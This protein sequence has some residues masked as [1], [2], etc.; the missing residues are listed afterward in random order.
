[1]DRRRAGLASWAALAAAACVVGGTAACQK[2]KDYPFYDDVQDPDDLGA[3]DPGRDDTGGKDTGRDP[4][5]GDALEAGDGAEDAAPD[6]PPA[7]D[8]ALRIAFPADGAILTGTLDVQVEVTSPA[9]A[10]WDLSIGFVNAAVSPVTR[11]GAGPATLA[12]PVDTT[13]LVDGAWTLRA[14]VKD[15]K[16]QE[17]AD[18][19][20]IT[21]DNTPPEVSVQVLVEGDGG[22]V[23]GR[24]ELVLRAKDLQTGIASARLSVD[25]AKEKEWSSGLDDVS[26]LLDAKDW[27]VGAHA[28]T[29]EAT[30]RAGHSGR[31]DRVVRVV[32]PPTI[33]GF[34]ERANQWTD[35]LTGGA[36][37]RLGPESSAPWGAVLA[38]TGNVYLLEKISPAL[39]FHPIHADI[40][41]TGFQVADLDQDGMDDAVGWCAKEKSFLVLLQRQEGERPVFQEIQVPGPKEVDKPLDVRDFAL[42]DVSQDGFPDI[43]A[44][45]AEPQRPVALYR[46]SPI[47][48]SAAFRDP[49]RFAGGFDPNLV[50]VGDLADNG[51]NAITIATSAV[52]TLTVFPVTE[53]GIVLQGEN[54]FIGDLDERGNPL[55]VDFSDLLPVMHP[56]NP[57]PKA[58]HRLFL[59]CRE[60]G[61]TL[62]NL[63]SFAAV[64][65]DQ[66]FTLQRMSDEGTA[67]GPARIA[68]G[69][70]DGNGTADAVV[71]DVNSRILQAWRFTSMGVDGDAYSPGLPDSLSVGR[72][73]D[74]TLADLEGDGPKEALLI[75]PDHL[76]AASWGRQEVPRAI[77]GGALCAWMDQ[78]GASPIAGSLPAAQAT[79]YRP[80]QTVVGRF[81]HSEEE[82]APRGLDL[83]TF[84]VT[85]GGIEVPVKPFSHDPAWGVPRIPD[86]DAGNAANPLKGVVGA[87]AGDMTPDRPEGH[88]LDDVLVVND[89]CD[90]SKATSTLGAVYHQVDLTA[91]GQ[92]ETRVVA[93]TQ[94]C[95]PALATAGQFDTG[96][97]IASPEG[98]IAV[99]TDATPPTVAVFSRIQSPS[100]AAGSTITLTK[101]KVPLRKLVAASMRRSLAEATSGGPFETDLVTLNAGTQDFTVF[102]ALGNLAL[103]AEGAS[104][105]FSVG[106]PPVDMAVGYLDVPVD[107]SATPDQAA[108]HLPDVVVLSTQ[109]LHVSFSL[110]NVDEVAADSKTLEFLPPW[111]VEYPKLAT[112]T[113]TLHRVALSDVNGDGYLDILVLDRNRGELA[114]YLNL[115]DRTFSLVGRY[116]V[117]N[118]PADLLPGDL[119]GDGRIDMTTVNL[120]GHTFTFVRTFPAGTAP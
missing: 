37:I 56:A 117:G 80:N 12:V 81:F 76:V 28:I 47:A 2:D 11:S 51:R 78:E 93:N 96:R 85:I 75:Y 36:G 15:A 99:Y 6:A 4:V 23:T 5:E 46:S 119:D 39:A 8:L 114:V 83:E 44:V 103:S 49:E 3:T 34:P 58:S 52:P 1:M 45:V 7:G 108:G 55:P 91:E 22:A 16:G 94:L 112:W 109:G 67:L 61:V 30:D 115:S 32:P 24:I 62:P 73:V 43:V 68:G 25:G 86:Q 113:P 54:N 71:L 9:G 90:P 41:C 89:R 110:D 120:N 66:S 106:R 35:P 29:L 40:A 111:Y 70:L 63:R 77:D 21:I 95:Q 87:F 26:F 100:Q 107:G 105:N 20:R 65:A 69:D 64:P 10:T 53:D 92:P 60:A 118:D 98:E 14:T 88:P 104:K 42:G 84:S 50:A 18:E 79:C 74:V 31:D 102:I 19:A 72:A 48:G 97:G 82:T 101:S 116:P 38:S 59:S 17:A 33:A 27:V 57:G 13:T